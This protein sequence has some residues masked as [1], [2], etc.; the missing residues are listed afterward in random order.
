M[1]KNQDARYAAVAIS[2]LAAICNVVCI[3]VVSVAW[4]ANGN[5]YLHMDLITGL[6]TAVIF[7][8]IAQ[9]VFFILAII[10]AYLLLS[11]PPSSKVKHS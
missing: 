5:T 8:L 11:L 4:A 9:A 3:I 7:V 10:A 2:I 6:Y 1:D